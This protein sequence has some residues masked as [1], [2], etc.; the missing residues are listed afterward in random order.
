MEVFTV[1]HSDNKLMTPSSISAPDAKQTTPASAG[2]STSFFRNIL[3][4]NTSNKDDS[5]TSRLSYFSPG[6][7]VGRTPLHSKKRLSVSFSVIL[8]LFSYFKNN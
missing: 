2:S 8:E 5:L 7:S 4:S 6:S 3:H 1:D